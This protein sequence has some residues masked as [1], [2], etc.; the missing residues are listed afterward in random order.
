M[1][2]SKTIIPYSSTLFQAHKRVGFFLQLDWVDISRLFFN[3]F[4]SFSLVILL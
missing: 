3:P 4:E 2:L 1:N